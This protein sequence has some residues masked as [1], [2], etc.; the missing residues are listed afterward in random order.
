MIVYIVQ[1]TLWIMGLVMLDTLY[2]A[3]YF[4]NFEFAPTERIV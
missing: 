2:I 4:G 1:D 3:V